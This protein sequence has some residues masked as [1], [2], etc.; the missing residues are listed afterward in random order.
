MKPAQTKTPC[1]WGQTTPTSPSKINKKIQMEKEIA[2]VFL[3]GHPISRHKHLFAHYKATE[4]A[5]ILNSENI[6]SLNDKE[7][8]LLVL[9]VKKAVKTTQKGATMAYLTLEDHTGGLDALVFPK[10]FSSEHGKLKE[11]VPLLAIGRINVQ[12]GKPK[13]FADTFA[14]PKLQSPKVKS[15]AVTKLYLQVTS[16]QSEVVQQIKPILQMHGGRTPVCIYCRKSAKVNVASENLWVTISEQ[17]IHD[18]QNVVGENNVKIV[19]K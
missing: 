16:M 7:V 6:D 18:L 4:I 19:E 1:F 14:E 11:G 12:D 9:I 10:R 3:S 2:G 17:L 13:F 15:P 8:A 5:K